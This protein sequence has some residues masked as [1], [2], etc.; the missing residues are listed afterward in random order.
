MNSV[1]PELEEWVEIGWV[2]TERLHF[3]FSLSCIGER[4]GNPLQYSC[5]EN[6][7]GGGAWWAASMGSHRV[8]HDWS[9]L[10]AAATEKRKEGKK[11]REQMETGKHRNSLGTSQQC[12]SLGPGEQ[13]GQSCRIRLQRRTEVNPLGTQERQGKESVVNTRFFK[14]R[15]K[16]LPICSHIAYIYLGKIFLCRR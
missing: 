13:E 8:G 11:K 15:R 14:Q 4:N 1:W 12:Y 16:R 5:L 7:R 6:P 10:A 9:D 2:S 3:H